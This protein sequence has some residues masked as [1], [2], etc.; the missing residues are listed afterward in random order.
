MSKLRHEVKHVVTLAVIALLLML[1]AS[2]AGYSYGEAHARVVVHCYAPDPDMG[3]CHG[4]VFIA[5]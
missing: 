5:S 3:A 1:A 4:N 2:L